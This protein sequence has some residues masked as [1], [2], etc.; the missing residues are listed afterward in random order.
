[1]E[2]GAI[3][4]IAALG[5]AVGLTFR[6][7]FLLGMAAILLAITLIYALSHHYSFLGSLIIV[8]VAQTLLQG[9]YFAGL[10][11]RSLLSPKLTDISAP[12]AKRLQ[13]RD[14]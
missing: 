11:G 4:V 12:E 8:V 6:L 14:S 13:Q 10:M 5:A 9:G 1:M 7:R 2:Y 3:G